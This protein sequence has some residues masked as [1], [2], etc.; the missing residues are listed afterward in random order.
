VN[1]TNRPA[2]VTRGR[3]EVLSRRLVVHQGS[4]LSHLLTPSCNTRNDELVIGPA[5]DPA[6]VADVDPASIQHR[7]PY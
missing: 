7:Q 5:L 2:D 6:M 4:H 3:A 1:R